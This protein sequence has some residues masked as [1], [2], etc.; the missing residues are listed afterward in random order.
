MGLRAVGLLSPGD[1][2]H[3]VGRVLINHDMPVLTCLVGRSKR[4]QM[5]A[6][7]TGIK[8]V[9]TYDNLVE[10]ADLILSILVPGEAENAALN[11]AKSLKNVDGSIVYVD[12]NAISPATSKRIDKI[13]KDAG[14]SYVDASII[15]PPPVRGRSTK[16]YASGSDVEEFKSLIDY[17]LEVRIL[18][19]E[20]GLGKGIKMTYGALTKGVTGI[21]TQLLA[22]A[23]KMGVYDSLVSLFEETQQEQYN[24]MK[25]MVPTMPHKARRWVSEMEEI[26]KTFDSCGMTPRIYQGLAELYKFIGGTSLAE[27]TAETYDKDRTLKQVIRILGENLL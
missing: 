7:K 27:E 14:S 12:C 4:T 23:W 10:A 24:R 18:G 15:G 11:V 8:A 25:R 13:I 1:M 22:A 16:F 5:L 9:P 19:S 6:E 17:G 20:I 2:G 26:S 3:A 21:S